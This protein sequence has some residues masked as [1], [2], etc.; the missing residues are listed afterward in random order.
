MAAN[1]AT[2]PTVGLARCTSRDNEII[3][4]TRAALTGVL[5]VLF[6]G[7]AVGAV[8]AGIPEKA[9]GPVVDRAAGLSAGS[10]PRFSDGSESESAYRR[11]IASLPYE[12]A[13]GYT[14]PESLPSEL[15]DPTALFEEGYVEGRA[16]SYWACSW[17]VAILEA[18]ASGDGEVATEGI[19]MLTAYGSLPWTKAHFPDYDVWYADVVAPLARN[20]TS[21]LEAL[22]PVECAL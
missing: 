13:H 21:A 17:S 22:T 6:G 9:P 7:L 10:N 2:I 14:W 5:A 3:T 8:A 18:Y 19:A 11:A 1:V 4:K 20:D 12:L 15:V 16:I